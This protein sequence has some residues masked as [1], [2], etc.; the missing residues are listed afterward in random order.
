MGT[1]GKFDVHIESLPADQV[2]NGRCLTFGPYPRVLGVRG[3][4][5]MVER[6]MRCMLTPIGTHPSD[7][8]YGTPLAAAFGGNT[9]PTTLFALA[10]QSVALASEKI[11]EY[12]SEYALPDDERLQLAQIERIDTDDTGPGV[13]VYVSLQNAA[14]SSITVPLPTL[15]G[16][17]SNG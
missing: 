9:D 12:D 8:D 14:G 11:Q 15:V 4:Y 5:K 7:R 17:T 2:V 6:F 1:T 3:I 16:S 10:S 13:T